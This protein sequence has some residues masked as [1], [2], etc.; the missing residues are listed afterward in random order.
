MEALRQE[1]AEVYAKQK[2][3]WQTVRSFLP[4]SGLRR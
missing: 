2:K 3:R 1:I 4:K